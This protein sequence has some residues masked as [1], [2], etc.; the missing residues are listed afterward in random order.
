MHYN[1]QLNVM[2][3]RLVHAFHEEK[4]T[5]YNCPSKEQSSWKSY[6][7]LGY[8]EGMKKCEKS[9]IKLIQSNHA[10]ASEK[11]IKLNTFYSVGQMYYVEELVGNLT[12]RKNITPFTEKKQNC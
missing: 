12:R 3:T 10:Y 8:G 2:N 6:R 1:L 4:N 9:S 11:S 7:K 5:Q